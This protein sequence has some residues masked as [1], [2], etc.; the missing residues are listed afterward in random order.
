LEDGRA[1]AEAL[2]EADEVREAEDL[3]D[4]LEAFVEELEA[5]VEELEAFDD[6]LIKG[7]KSQE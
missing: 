2:A 5:F 1:D 6:V 7:R 4:E 3:V